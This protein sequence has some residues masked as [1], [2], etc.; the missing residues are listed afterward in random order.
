MQLAKSDLIIP[1]QCIVRALTIVVLSVPLLIGRF[2]FAERFELIKGKGEPVCRAYLES[3]EK[4]SARSLTQLICDRT[5]FTSG[6]RIERF[7][8]VELDLWEHRAFFD[9]AGTYSRV[10]WPFLFENKVEFDES[11][12]P[13][14]PHIRFFAFPTEVD[15]DNDGNPDRVV[16]ITGKVICGEIGS[17][18]MVL[19]AKSGPS[20]SPE[21]I[22]ELK[23]SRLMYGSGLDGRETS[24]VMDLLRFQG[25]FYFDFVP[26][27]RAANDRNMFYVM[28]LDKSEDWPANVCQV[29]PIPGRQ[30]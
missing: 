3:L 5:K 6:S 27:G 21:S 26:V 7:P 28:R 17:Y 25:K 30:K 9:D 13:R 12:K 23:T 19:F 11:R 16:K 20:T 8:A 29:R 14:S 15:L 10:A 1:I 2:A 4:S 18:Q 24:A 22:D